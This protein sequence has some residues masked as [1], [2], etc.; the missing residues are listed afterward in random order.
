MVAAGGSL[1]RVIPPSIPMVI[2]VSIAPTVSVAALFVAG[3]LPGT[4]IGVGFMAVVVW[5]VRYLDLASAAVE[6]A[7][8]GG[9]GWGH[10][11]RVALAAR[12]ALRCD[13]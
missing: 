2:Y 3:I 5:R 13:V 11:G 7:G 6:S 4:L 8:T 12:P 1:G 9:A 10:T